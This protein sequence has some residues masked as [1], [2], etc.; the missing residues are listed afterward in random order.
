MLD[1]LYFEV[2]GSNNCVKRTTMLE[3][4][5]SDFPNNLEP[6]ASKYYSIPKAARFAYRCIGLNISSVVVAGFFPEIKNIVMWEDAK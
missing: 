5:D 6:G 1:Q 3:V 2:M 4:A